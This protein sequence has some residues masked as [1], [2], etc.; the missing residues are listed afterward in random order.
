MKTKEIYI[1]EDYYQ[2]NEYDSFEIEFSTDEERIEQI[3]MW[4][5]HTSS[6]YDSFDTIEELK[7]RG[8][9]GDIMENVSITKCGNG[10]EI[11]IEEGTF[12]NEDGEEEEF[13]GG[14]LNCYQL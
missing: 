14:Y 5:L 3:M 9:Y 13:G 2:Q 11:E 8:V 6:S 7:E 1:F 10:Y 12:I 4:F